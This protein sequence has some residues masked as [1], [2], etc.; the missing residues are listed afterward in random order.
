MSHPAASTLVHMGVS[1]R[2]TRNTR[3]YLP[4]WAAIPVYLVAG[5]IWLGILI[6]AVIVWLVTQAA[7]GIA[8]LTHHET[9]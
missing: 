1:V 5:A 2:V 4:F 6:V 3:V 8:T 7:R 9:K